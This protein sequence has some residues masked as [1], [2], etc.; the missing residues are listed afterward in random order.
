L[1]NLGIIVT[2]DP[3]RATHLAAPSILRTHKF[4]SALAYA[5]TV[6]ST[7]FIDKCL[8]KDEFLEPNGFLLQDKANEKR[9]HMTL[10]E[11]QKRAK[12]N[13]NKLFQGRTIYCVEN[14][15]GGFDTFKSIIE[16]NGGQCNMYRGRPGTMVPSRR[17][18]S[19]TSTTEDDA[20]AEVLLISGPD[21]EQ[22]RI[23]SRFRQMAEGSRK[24][25]KIIQ[26]DWLL[27]SA[28]AQKVL[29]VGN[30]ELS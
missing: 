28:M 9:F 30:H 26:S 17:P 23:W 15:N 2:Q 8:E 21:K 7:D 11:S 19:E 12:E 14:I 1:R 16:A 25:P 5:P 24:V 20:E 4:V 29:P 10:A 18:D 3:S 27:E 6:L 13:R 22:A